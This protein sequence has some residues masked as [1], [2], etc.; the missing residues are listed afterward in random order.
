ME[1]WKNR[2]VSSI[3]EP[4]STFKSIVAAAALEEGIVAPNDWFMDPGFLIVSEKRIENW[5]G[6][7]FGTVT[8]TDVMKQS[9]NTCFALIGLDLGAD[10]LN[11]YARR[12]VFG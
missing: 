1:V 7:S 10:R 5:S 8:F 3:Y 2:A 4:G 12:F 6:D 9:I 11:K